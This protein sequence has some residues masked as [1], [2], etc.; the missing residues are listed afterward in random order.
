MI[1]NTFYRHL[2]HVLMLSFIVANTFGFSLTRSA[3][4]QFAPSFLSSVKHTQIPQLHKSSNKNIALSSTMSTEEPSTG[5]I[6][7][8][9]KF[10]LYCQLARIVMHEND[11]NFTSRYVDLPNGEQLQPWFARINPKMII[12]SM[13]LENGEIVSE[14]RT[15]MKLMDKKC[16]DDQQNAVEKIMDIAYSCDLGWFSTVAMKKKVWLWKIIQDSG[17]M[18]KKVKSTILK[19]A[20][21]NEDLRDVY[22][23]KAKISE[24]DVSSEYNL[25]RREPIQK[26]LDNLAVAVKNRKEG[27][28]ITGPE[29]TRADAL[30]AIYVQWVK[31]QVAWD[32]SLLTLDPVLDAFYDE[33]KTRPSFVKTL[34]VEPKWVGYYWRDRLAPVQNVAVVGVIAIGV[35]LLRRFVFKSLFM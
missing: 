23:Q 1:C 34:D 22:L 3:T 2:A 26:C 8:D 20:E 6:L 27:E 16:P 7:Y 5:N 12:P 10:S 11:I 4:N 21:E 14:S 19:F 15:I 9:T 24:K 33:V 32:S 25:N 30:V 29:F 31:W 28:W 35:T 18:E 17:M 13:K